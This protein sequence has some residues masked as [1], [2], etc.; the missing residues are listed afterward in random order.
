MVEVGGRE[1]GGKNAT[2]M[3]DKIYLS[4]CL[5]HAGKSVEALSILRDVLEAEVRVQGPKHHH[6]MLAASTLAAILTCTGQH[7][8][9]ISVFRI[10]LSAQ[11][12]VLGVDHHTTLETA[13]MVGVTFVLLKR[14]DEGRGILEDTLPMLVRE[15]GKDDPTTVLVTTTLAWIKIDASD[16]YSWDVACLSPPGAVYDAARRGQVDKVVSCPHSLIS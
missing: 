3:L 10:A 16:E 6:T 12:D 4:I 9:A 1:L 8:D 15:L 2:V 14:P 5:H 7:E 13:S 11:C